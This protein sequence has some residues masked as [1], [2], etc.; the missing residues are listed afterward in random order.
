MSVRVTLLYFGQA[1]DGSGSA[2]EEFQLPKGARVEDL[3][4]RAETKHPRLK[5][6]MG[7]AQLAL[8]EEITAGDAILEEGDVVAILPPVAGG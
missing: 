8:N 2:Q 3:V 7:T 1:R 5:R 6:M 4:E